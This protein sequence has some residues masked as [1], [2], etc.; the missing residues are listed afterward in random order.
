MMTRDQLLTMC[1]RLFVTL[2]KEEQLELEDWLDGD[3][4][5]LTDLIELLYNMRHEHESK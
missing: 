2:T 5:A 3:P 4:D 1:R